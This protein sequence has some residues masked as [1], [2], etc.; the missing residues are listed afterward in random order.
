MHLAEDTLLKLAT[1]ART[2][3]AFLTIFSRIVT[4]VVDI[5]DT[6]SAYTLS[7]ST[8]YLAIFGRD[9]RLL[10]EQALAGGPGVLRPT[11][12]AAAHALALART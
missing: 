4:I 2:C 8:A 11:V 12:A 3:G 5:A 6:L 9:A 10:V 7:I 1:A